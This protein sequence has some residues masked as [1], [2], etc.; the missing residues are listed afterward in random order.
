LCGGWVGVK[1]FEELF[2]AWNAWEGGAPGT[3]QIAAWCD[4][5]AH[6]ATELR[7]RLGPDEDE[8]FSSW[9]PRTI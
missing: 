4:A 6:A 3:D 9:P 5:L 1:P 7:K 2:A 8:S